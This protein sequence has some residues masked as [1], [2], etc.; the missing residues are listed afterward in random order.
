MGF[1]RKM[2]GIEEETEQPKVEPKVDESIRAFANKDYTELFTNMGEGFEYVGKSFNNGGLKHF[3]NFHDQYLERG[4]ENE[5]ARIMD[6][7]RMSSMPEIADVIEDAVIESTQEDLNGDILTLDITDEEIAE[8]ENIVKTLNDEF[9]NLFVKKL[10]IGD[11]IWDLFKT[12]YIDGRVF[13]ERI[14]NEKDK[15]KGIQTLRRLP[16]ETMDFEFDFK[17]G[18]IIAFYQYLSSNKTRPI[19][20]EEAKK[21]EANEKDIIIF[22]PSQI[23]FID[24][25][26]YGKT[27]YEIFGFLEKCKVPY[28]QLKLLETS[29]IIYRIIRAPE[30]FVFKIDTG[31]M[32]ADKA[33]KFVQAMKDRML[34]K[35]T[36][37]PQTGRL[38]NEPE[39]LSILEN[40]F[41]PVSSD[42]RGSDITTVGGNPTG[43]TELSD[44][45]YFAKK[46]YRALK[47]PM[48]RVTAKE[49]RQDSSVLFANSPVGE[50]AR[51]EIKW[52]VFLERQQNKFCSDFEKIFLMHLE[53][54]GF[55]KQYNLDL[56]K[57]DIKM[58]PPSY[59]KDRQQQ[60]L[61]ESRMTNYLQLGQQPEF[62]KTYL[63]KRMLDWSDE[64]IEANAEALKKDVELGLIPSLPGTPEG[65]EAPMTEEPTET[66]EGEEEPTEETPEREEGGVPKEITGPPEG[67]E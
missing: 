61:L 1:W 37:D 13:Y 45:Y 2:F 47:Y 46:L 21:R 3:L 53:F 10:K 40:F 44:V 35:R 11:I 33:M 24:Y 48:S 26:V 22:E 27:R 42:G 55:K 9:D 65:E 58:S 49:D 39:V 67:E 36:Y 30:R 25:G 17:S 66:P 63:M 50:I 34:K 64:E 8:N 19:N 5:V 62:A 14:I 20:L 16:S 12:Y 52:S 28:N 57:F 43:F 4:F 56:S 6:Y 7:R 18:K 32:P 59:Y 15:A 23:S 31:Q 29:V 54:K 60:L 41:I 38:T 51:D